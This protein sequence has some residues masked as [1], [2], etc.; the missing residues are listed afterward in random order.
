V[1]LRHSLVR[2]AVWLG[3]V[4][5][6]AYLKKPDGA[7]ILAVRGDALAWLGGSVLAA[8]LVIHLWSNVT[9][10]RSEVAS[11]TASTRL[12]VE[13][14][15]RYVRNPIYLAGV[16]LLLGTGLLYSRRSGADILAPAAVAALFSLLCGAFRRAGI[17]KA[18]RR[19]LRRVL[20][21][22]PKVASAETRHFSAMMRHSGQRNLHWM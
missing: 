18:I 8:G 21:P 16:L 2:S 19:R 10:A 5:L 7:S 22:R 11:D 3:A 15:F 9:L 13:G 20:P 6:L 12:V 17:T 14:P 1:T 4:A